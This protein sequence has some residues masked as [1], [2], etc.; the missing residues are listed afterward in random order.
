M[1]AI[2]TLFIIVKMW[3]LNANQLMNG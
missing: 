1:T 2:E 3:K